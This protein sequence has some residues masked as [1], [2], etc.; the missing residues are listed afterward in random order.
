MQNRFSTNFSE[1]C[2][3]HEFVEKQ[4]SKDAA[5]LLSTYKQEQEMTY[6]YQTTL[7]FVIQLLFILGLPY[8]HHQKGGHFL[9]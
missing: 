4:R 2:R 9:F 3:K 8:F 7:L 5:K 1:I 6:C